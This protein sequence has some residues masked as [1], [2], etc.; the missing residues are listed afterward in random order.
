MPTSRPFAVRDAK[1]SGQG[2]N[3]HVTYRCGCR[4]RTHSCDNKEIR[5][6]YIEDFVLDQLEKRV[7]SEKAI[8]KL[9]A[10]LNEY[11]EQAAAGREAENEPLKLELAATD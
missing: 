4:H 1:Y 6:E 11:Q 10:Q 7:F 2:K 8:P 5:R 9:A 3:L